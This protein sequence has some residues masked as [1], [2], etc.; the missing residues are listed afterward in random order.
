MCMVT[1]DSFNNMTFCFTELKTQVKIHYTYKNKEK[2]TVAFLNNAH[3]L[4][5]SEQQMGFAIRKQDRQS[6]I[7]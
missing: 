7:F 1:G 4:F 2:P 6:Q 3:V 5:Y